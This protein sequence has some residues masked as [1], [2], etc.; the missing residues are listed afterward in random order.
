MTEPTAS[1]PGELRD[2]DL[3]A[4]VARVEGY[5]FWQA[6]R[7]TA[8]AEAELFCDRLPWLTGP[9]RREVARVYAGQ[10][11][12]EVREELRTVV[13]RYERARQRT[14]CRATAAVLVTLSASFAAVVLE[15]FRG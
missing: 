10:K 13:D 7:R 12:T 14:V 6:Q 2:Q 5:L 1:G 8:Q 15:R 9:Q 11:L 4:G 3:A